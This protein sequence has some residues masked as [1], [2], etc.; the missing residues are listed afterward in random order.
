LILQGC[1]IRGSSAA[2]VEIDALGAAVVI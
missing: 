2:S 1:Q